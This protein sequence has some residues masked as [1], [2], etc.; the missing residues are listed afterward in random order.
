MNLA[1]WSQIVYVQK[2][3][4]SPATEMQP[5]LGW[6]VLYVGQSKSS[7]IAHQ[8]ALQDALSRKN[9]IT[10]LKFSLNAEIMLWEV[11]L[12]MWSGLYSWHRLL[13]LKIPN[14]KIREWMLYFVW[15]IS[16]AT[17]HGREAS[18]PQWVKWRDLYDRMTMKQQAGIPFISDASQA[19]TALFLI[20]SLLGFL[21]PGLPNLFLTLG[22]STS[23]YCLFLILGESKV[24]SVHIPSGD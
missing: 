23:V 9:V 3:V 12:S 6:K 7:G 15:N 14:W 24:K 4:I 22:P 1:N 13:L 18:L 19:V 16:E 11:H 20:W 5:L 21:P 8:L 10:P 17:P 2:Y